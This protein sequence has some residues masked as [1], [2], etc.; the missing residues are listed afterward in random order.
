MLGAGK[1]RNFWADRR[2]NV[3]MI[4]G[5]VMIPIIGVAGFAIDAQLTFAQKNKVQYAIDSATL[6]GAR[7]LQTTSNEQKVLKHARAYFESI[8][9]DMGNGLWCDNFSIKIMGEEEVEAS[10]D[11][12]QPTTLSR[13][14]GKEQ[15]QFSVTSTAVYGIGK[16]DV[17]FVFDVSG[18]MNSRGRLGSLKEAAID[19][20]N[21]ILP[22]PGASGAGDVR[23]AMA[24]YNSMVNAGPYFEE[25]TGMNPRR[26]YVAEITDTQEQCGWV[27]TNYAGNSGHC[28]DW[29]YRCETTSTTR[30][31]SK[32]LTSTCVWER[33]G[34]H[35]FTDKQPDQL[36]NLELT[37]KDIPAGTFDLRSASGNS[38]GFMA[39]A[40]AYWDGSWDRMRTDGVSECL[41]IDPFELNDNIEKIENY[42]EALYANGGTAGHQGIAWGWYLISPEW[43]D[44]FNGKAT[45][46]G[47]DEPDSAKAMII[48][49]DG[50]FNQQ[51][52]NGQGNSVAQ[53]K[54]L[55]DAIKEKDVLI[56]TVAFEAPTSGKRVL[57]YCASG[58]EFY[59][60]AESGEQ[61]IATY[62]AIATQI[63]DL[64]IKG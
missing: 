38:E 62:K 19:A 56:Y 17:A 22:E 10:V 36:T 61:L 42:I 4:F 46:L 58:R 52:F 29:D 26:T 28:R 15:L 24:A 48:M 8:T 14:L 32:R 21:I 54:K 39:S 51:F 44:V 6:A 64:R 63:S 40:Y 37:D 13:I 20:A 57:E 60:E 53:A 33:G 27:C 3:A 9:A 12:F 55:C 50:E 11:C 35:A 2:G 45:P 49:T 34:D 30:T 18:S 23:I 16:L 7:M 1:I 59:F 41:N 5:I 47:Y 31:E 25:V 43:S